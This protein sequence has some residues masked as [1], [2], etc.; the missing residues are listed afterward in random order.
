MNLLREVCRSGRTGVQVKSNKDEGPTALMAVYV[1]EHALP[2]TH[3]RLV[4]E[5]CWGTHGVRSSSATSNVR[6]THQPVEVCNLRR[7]VN[8]C[9][10]SGGIQRV[11]VDDDPEGFEWCAT[12]RNWLEPG[13]LA[14]FSVFILPGNRMAWEPRDPFPTLLPPRRESD[15]DGSPNSAEV[16]RTSE[17]IRLMVILL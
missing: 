8:V 11:V 12:A 1:D 14:P 5:R 16:S 13:A 15:C 6:Q 9:Q 7:I 17:P 10:R 4:R 2:K 3:V